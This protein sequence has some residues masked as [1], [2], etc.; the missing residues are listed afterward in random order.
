MRNCAFADAICGK[1]FGNY[2]Y[3]LIVF[4]ICDSFL[5]RAGFAGVERP[6]LPG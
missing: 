4:E 1:C 2:V 3:M 6:G 5:Q